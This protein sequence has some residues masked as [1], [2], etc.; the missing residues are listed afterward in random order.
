MSSSFNQFLSNDGQGTIFKSYSH[1]SR[2]FVD[3]NFARAP[4]LGFLFFVAFNINSGVIKDPAWRGKFGSS[5]VGLLV[6]DIGL[7]KFKIK[8]EMMNQYNRK[9]QVQTQLTYDPV[10]IEFWD[11]N[12]EITNGLWKNYYNYYYTDSLYGTETK[13][14]PGN[15][16]PTGLKAF[17]DTKF[18]GTDNPYGFNNYQTIPFFDSIDVFVLHQGKFTQMRLVNPLVQSWEH[19]TL[20]VKEA[21]KALVNKMVVAYE[22]VLYYQGSIIQGENPQ[23]FAAQ[24]YDKTPSPLKFGSNSNSKPSDITGQ[25]DSPITKDAFSQFNVGPS[26]SQLEKAQT[27]QGGSGFKTTTQNNNSG[28][29]GFNINT[30]ADSNIIPS[31]PVSLP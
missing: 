22:D 19:D 14:N 24:Y 2:L 6:K 5:D 29:L 25:G 20:S 30:G 26:Q 11:D 21:D 8:T 9:T 1:A 7:P 4:K 15:P 18:G 13:V 16:V 10:N 28:R 12:S 17:G 3:N 31:T 23:G 27:Q